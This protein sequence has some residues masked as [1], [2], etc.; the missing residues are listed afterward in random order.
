MYGCLSLTAMPVTCSMCPVKVSF[1][2]PDAR[3][4]ILIVRSALPVA[5]HS[6]DGSTVTLLTQPWWPLMTRYNFQGACHSGLCHLLASL[7]M[8]CALCR[9]FFSLTTEPASPLNVVIAPL[10]PAA[11]AARRFAF[12][13]SSIESI[14]LLT[15]VSFPA[16]FAFFAASSP[17][18]ASSCSCPNGGLTV[19]TFAAS[20]AAAAP[21]FSLGGAAGACPGTN[22][23]RFRTCAYSSA[24]LIASLSFVLA[25]STGGR[26]SISNSSAVRL[27]RRIISSRTV[28]AGSTGSSLRGS[29]SGSKA[30]TIIR[31]R[32]STGLSPIAREVSDASFDRRLRGRSLVT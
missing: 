8:T 25:S 18:I 1:S 14:S 24:I 20:A 9:Y 13:S 10:I 17:G 7:G 12:S 3:S 30:G 21:T 16:F 31:P 15:S 19:A 23:G 6:F 29:A 11:A 4:Q 32:Y 5:N 27:R 26:S 22:S 28:S 2:C